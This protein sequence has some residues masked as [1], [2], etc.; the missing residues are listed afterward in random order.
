MGRLVADAVVPFTDARDVNP[1][2]M[3][4]TGSSPNRVCVSPA[5]GVFVSKLERAL[6]VKQLR[7]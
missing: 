4:G 1:R 7:I 2:L 6:R 3:T 5:G